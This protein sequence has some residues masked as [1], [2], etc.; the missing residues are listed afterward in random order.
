MQIVFYIS[1]ENLIKNKVIT[2]L[3][4]NLKYVGKRQILSS[5]KN[6]CNFI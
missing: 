3:Q 6:T 1:T 2:K 5:T 4:C